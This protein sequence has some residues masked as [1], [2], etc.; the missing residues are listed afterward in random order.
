MA[1]SEMQAL[2]GLQILLQSKTFAMFFGAILVWFGTFLA[3]RQNAKYSKILK[4]IELKHDKKLKEANYLREQ[5]QRV[6]GPLQYYASLCQICFDMNNAYY[7][8]GAKG[9]DTRVDMSWGIEIVNQLN[10][11]RHEDIEKIIDIQ[12]E[13]I[14]YT[15]KF[16]Q[17]VVDILQEHYAFIDI[18]D[19]NI[20]NHFSKDILRLNTEFDEN[21]LKTSLEVYRHLEEISF[22]RPE[23]IQRVNE[24]FL[25]KQEQLRKLGG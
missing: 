1:A 14:S 16:G 5:L 8:A 9:I 4:D 10:K 13:Y 20:F 2:D 23:F 22:M 15:R 24:K 6:Y 11:K 21:G 19:M 18:D 3:N 25:V 17:K 12:N 7:D